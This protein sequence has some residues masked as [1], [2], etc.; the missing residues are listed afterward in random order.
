MFSVCVQA[1]DQLQENSSCVLL[2]VRDEGAR[3]PEDSQSDVG[4][5]Y[6]CVYSPAH[7]GSCSCLVWLLVNTASRGQSWDQRSFSGPVCRTWQQQWWSGPYMGRITKHP[8]TPTPAG[9]S[10][11]VQSGS[12]LV[13]RKVPKLSINQR[14]S[15]DKKSPCV[16]LQCLWEENWLNSV[17]TC[18]KATDKHRNCW[19][20]AVL[21]VIFWAC[22][23]VT[24]KCKKEKMFSH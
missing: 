7:V 16:E 20:C 9:G 1:G 15:W 19:C 8:S 10:T 2:V 5:S 11:V 18:F 17:L 6:C 4:L 3:R 13:L 12:L 14:Q 24:L 23:R 22:N 21:D